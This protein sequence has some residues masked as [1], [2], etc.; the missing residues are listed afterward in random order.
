MEPGTYAEL[1]RVWKKGDQ[2]EL[3][4][5]M[6]ATLIEANPLVEENRN[7]IAV[8]RGP[9]VYCLESIDLPGKSIFNAFVPVNTTF[10]A[11]A[12]TISGTNMMSL[13]GKAKLESPNNW[14]KVLY[15]PVEDKSTVAEIKLIPYFAWGNRGHSEMSVWLPLSR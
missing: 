13:V 6:E 3:N 8:K 5:P 9:I 15:R 14:S 1:N 2:V 4:L 7:Q 10:E 12:I 11:K